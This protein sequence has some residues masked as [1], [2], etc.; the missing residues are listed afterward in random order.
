MPLYHP[1]P[2]VL[3]RTPLLSTDHYPATKL[4][5]QTRTLLLGLFSRPE[6]QEALTIASPGLADELPSWLSK[7]G[8]QDPT[9][10]RQKSFRQLESSLLK[11]AIRMTTRT[12]PFGAFSG[13]A[14]AVVDDQFALEVGDIEHH[15]TVTQIDLHHLWSLIKVMESQPGVSSKVRLFANS[16]FLVYGERAYLRDTNRHGMGDL[17]DASVRYTPAAREVL[18]CCGAAGATLADVSATLGIRYPDVPEVQF[19]RLVDSLLEAGFLYTSVRPTLTAVD[20]LEAVLAVESSTDAARE[21]AIFLTRFRQLTERLDRQPLGCRS[22]TLAALKKLPAP[23]TSSGANRRVDLTTHL[24][25][26]TFGQQVAVAAAEAFEVLGRITPIGRS[27]PNLQRYMERFQEAYGHREVPVVEL[28]DDGIGL[29]PPM[30]YWHPAPTVTENILPQDTAER[31][32]LLMQLA[33]NHKHDEEVELDETILTALESDP[34]WREHLPETGELFVQVVAKSQSDINAGRFDVVVGPSVATST[35]GKA[36]GRFHRSLPKAV[37]ESF[38]QV[39]A[40]PLEEQSLAPQTLQAEVSFLPLQARMMNVATKALVQSYEIPMGVPPSVTS[41]F[42][43]DLEDIVVGVNKEGF[44]LKSR[45]RNA[46]LSVVSSH[47]L[48]SPHA[49]NVVRFMEDVTRAQEHLFWA[50]Q[51]GIASE[52]PYTPRIRVGQAILA[53]R[54]WQVRFDQLPLINSEIID[55]TTLGHVTQWRRQIGL[56]RHV[57]IGQDDNLLHLD[58][59]DALHARLLIEELRKSKG[60]GTNRLVRIQESYALGQNVWAN[61]SH[62]ASYLQEFVVP[63]SKIS[64]KASKIPLTR[65]SSLDIPRE[66]RVKG[67]GSEWLYLKLYK[68]YHSDEE[69]L[70]ED[71]LPFIR[72][73]EPDL[74]EEWFFIR[75]RDPRHHLRLR[76]K[77]TAETKTIVM[78]RALAWADQLIQSGRV[79]EVQT[80][81]YERELERY[82]GITGM[83]MSEKFFTL[84]STFITQYVQYQKANHH[85]LDRQ[86]VLGGLIIDMVRSFWPLCDVVKF[87]DWMVEGQKSVFVAHRQATS[88]FARTYRPQLSKGIMSSLW[89][90]GESEA[91]FRPLLDA[92]TA[93]GAELYETLKSEDSQTFLEIMS[94]LAHMTCNRLGLTRLQE[95]QLYSALLQSARSELMKPRNTLRPSAMPV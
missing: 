95:F 53:P 89:L 47:M 76:L 6:V 70:T 16:N 69:I 56:C 42:I 28:L 86:V 41:E 64:S 38:R 11:Y 80:A 1:L 91:I 67:L 12:T 30:D 15:R 18:R 59:E 32:R 49:P 93:C 17:Q 5:S 39:H 54:T 65:I 92:R 24:N 26:A 63:F 19:G 52:L 27:R 43:I 3:V 61:T 2:H 73:L 23:D 66:E 83:I 72:E 90:D 50:F 40:R 68:A 35:A 34:Q 87:L 51:W 57:A 33:L 77:T 88:T 29:G 13:V 60:D 94:S 10:W 84:D 4:S 36:F 79:R 45:S 74:L 78:G 37:F 9:I 48:A 46:Y 71:I 82:G 58:L 20:P 44:Y 75:Y 22:L 55:E 62:G 81:S 31:D 7:A 14:S 8:S 25:K 21:V 85:T